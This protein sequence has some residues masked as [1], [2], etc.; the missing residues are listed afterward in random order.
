MSAPDPRPTG[1]HH[2]PAIERTFSARLRTTYGAGRDPEV[3]L[4]GEPG[5]GSSDLSTTF[6]PPGG[7]SGGPRERYSL[8]G[9]IAR[10]GMGAILKVF[11]NDL[12]R[13][14]AM[15]VILSQ[16]R[17]LADSPAESVDPQVLSRFLEEAQVTSQLDHPG[18]VPVHEL[19]ID[20][21]GRVYF[22]MQLVRGRDLR[23]YYQKV[24]EGGWSVTRA[25]N[26]LLKVCEATAFAHSRNVVHRDLK[27]ANIMVGKY[28]EVYVM[29]WGLARVLSRRDPRDLA[30][31]PG[32]GAEDAS[33]P[34]ETMDGTVI[35]TPF[36]MP[37]EQA[38]GR[39]SEIGPPADVYAVGAML[40]ELLAG[41]KPYVRGNERPHPR[42]VLSRVLAG[43]PPPLNEVAPAA[44]PEL[45]AICERAMAREP[46]ARYAS[47]DALAEDLRA[48]LEGRVV[49]AYETGALAELK[50]W[51]Q[52][53]RGMAAASA[54]ALVL[55]VV[56]LA[57]SLFFYVASERNAREV[58]RLADVKR[59]R[60][61]ELEAADLWPA[62]PEL[63][64]HYRDWIDRAAELVRRRELHQVT[65]TGMVPTPQDTPEQAWQ[66]ETLGGLVRDIDAL[67][68]PGGLLDNV[69]GRLAFALKVEGD[70]RTGRAAAELWQRAIDSIADPLR[71]P[72]YAGLRVRPQRGLLPLWRDE[73]SGLWEFLH[74][75][76]GA[77]PQRGDE[78]IEPTREMGI[79]LVL[80]PGG[81]FH[82]GASR[83][84]SSP[85][86][87]PQAE[88]GPDSLAPESP[89]HAIRLDPFFIS[90]YEMTQGQW[91]RITG[92]N[93]S[94][95]SDWNTAPGNVVYASAT[96]PVENV[97]WERCTDV[98]R[99][100]DLRLPTEA[101]WEY[102]ARGG[103][104][105]PWWTG[106]RVESIE[107]AA[108]I[109][110]VRL[111]KKGQ[112]NWKLE[113][114]LDDGFVIH[115][116]V[117]SFAKPH[118][119]GLFDTMGNVWEWC[120]EWFDHYA[121]NPARDG[122]GFRESGT[123]NSHVHR[124][125]SWADFALTQRSACR[126]YETRDLHMS[127]GLRPARR[128]DP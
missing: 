17:A 97:T 18:V 34:L 19:G 31:R 83:D 88:E 82:M 23:H 119:Y 46:A 101:Q 8:F 64:P 90:K 65:L 26:V 95:F 21:A 38:A 115:A 126:F 109:A 103:T 69:R 110:D 32:T 121:T 59:L 3:T 75:Q 29:D 93:P 2:L 37:P 114:W 43:P 76:S 80:L 87:D 60:D 20:A 5:D 74:L 111:V 42:T 16:D 41:A 105:T 85:N 62:H 54:A 11:D 56:G 70:T 100:L 77:P 94:K 128:L 22:T 120:Q 91:E 58:L 122:D 73:Q 52:R 117:G 124:G 79:V 116:P 51:V 14:L 123:R 50:K 96:S 81:T 108:N 113:E 28:G 57:V 1:F 84:E 72:A 118:P 86:H 106:E 125:G 35:G 44:P 89:V 104:H 107:G 61:L 45:V 99:W 10:G 53:N 67:A 25:L 39:T 71:C 112:P 36:Y 12:R 102:A 27:P 127:I 15:K 49:R 66:K 7:A 68:R 47:M 40:Y 9:E 24:R 30:P 13:T 78:R 98:M 63:E 48:W 6:P 92:S 4:E 55:L 33:S